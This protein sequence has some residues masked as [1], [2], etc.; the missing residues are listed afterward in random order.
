MSYTG[1]HGKVAVVTGAAQG[2]GEAVARLLAQ[3]GA[4]VAAVDI[5]E[6]QLD[7]LVTE[8]RSQGH[9]ATA[10]PVDISNHQSV[11]DAVQR[12]EMTLGPI[13][14][15]VNAAGVLYM[16]AVS[17]LRDEEW[18]RTFDVNTHGVFY[19]SRAVVR[20]MAERQS[21]AIVTVG[22]NASG[23]PRMHMSAYV[24]S[25]AASTMFTKCLALEY[26]SDHIR[27]N[28]VSPGSTD[29]DMQRALWAD[30]Q[31]AE[32]VIAGSPQA[33]RLGI[34]LNRLALPSD[35]ADSVLFLVSDQAR[36]ITMHNLCV[37]GGAT[38]GA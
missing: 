32:A 9:Q 5:R 16:G 35:I 34:P 18:T 22:S 31:G 10:C 3:Q 23:V 37:D 26:A 21:G 12:I 8:L 30:E 14:I 15:L 20:S 13:G 27:C 25:K 4:I 19:M 17:E 38:L 6:D 7:Q 1:I 33:Y 11:E 36:H 24:A 29:T 2:I 28:I